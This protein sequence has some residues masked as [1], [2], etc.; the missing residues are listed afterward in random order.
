MGGSICRRNEWRLW[1]EEG[2]MEE[3]VTFHT[4]QCRVK[5]AAAKLHR[6][7]R[8]GEELV[9]LVMDTWRVLGACGDL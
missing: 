8:F 1:K 9:D 4:G 5:D 7:R 6:R 3:E 2:G